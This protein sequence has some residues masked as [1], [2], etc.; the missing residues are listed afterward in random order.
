MARNF[1]E[2][3][4]ETVFANDDI[5]LLTKLVYPRFQQESRL[6]NNTVKTKRQSEGNFQI[7]GLP[8]KSKGKV[9]LAFNK[10]AH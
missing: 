9:A 2:I 7:W 10:T 6:D 1:W 5:Y 8:S 4:E 3:L